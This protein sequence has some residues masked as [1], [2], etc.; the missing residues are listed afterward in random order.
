VAGACKW[1]GAK[2]AVGYW[3]NSSW[4]RVQQE[5]IAEKVFAL[6]SDKLLTRGVP[7]WLY[8]PA[9]SDVPGSVICTCTKD[10]N[11]VSDRPCNE[12]YGTGFAPGYFRFLHETVFA[13]VSEA[14]GYT[15]TNCAIDKTIK[16]HRI[17]LDPTALSG[18]IETFDKSYSNLAGD[19]WSTKLDAFIRAAGNTATAQFST[20]GGITWLVLTAINGISKPIGTGIIRFKITLTRT[21]LESKSPAFE[22][23]RARHV[24]SQNYNEGRITDIR[25]GVLPGQI[26]I[27]RPWVVEQSSVDQG[28]GTLLDWAGDRSWTMPLNFFDKTILPDTLLAKLDDANAGPHPFF[29]H[30][31]GMKLGTR[32]VITN[33]K[34]SEELGVFTHQSFDERRAQSAESPYKLVF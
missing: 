33:I 14:S 29:E 30:A 2:G 20:D 15:L 12:C 24:L 3:G 31:S 23:I 7:V 4:C 9:F 10:T 26:L 17:L 16:P 18:T 34:Y 22:I 21:A 19:D 27:L 1:P 25:G 32:V 5:E 28:R 6:L 11:Q 8:K 13:G